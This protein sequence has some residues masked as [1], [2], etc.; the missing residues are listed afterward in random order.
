MGVALRERNLSSFHPSWA[1]AGG[2][3]GVFS[4]LTGRGSE[5]DPLMVMCIQSRFSE[6]LGVEMFNG[7][8]GIFEVFC[9]V[10][11]VV[12]LWRVTGPLNSV[13]KLVS[14]KAKVDDIFQFVFWFSVYFNRRKRSLDL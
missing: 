1:V 11:S 2:G 6:V 8:C 4:P 5:V 10:P 13:L 14:V 7:D 12:V 3:V 9:G